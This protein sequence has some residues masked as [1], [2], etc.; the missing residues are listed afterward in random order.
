MQSAMASEAPTITLDLIIEILK[1]VVAERT[2]GSQVKVEAAGWGR[3]TSL[4]EAGFNSYDFVEIIFKIEDRFG[5]EIDYN[6][7]NGVNDARTIG[8]I[9]EALQKL[10]AKKQVS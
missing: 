4:E 3:D 5:I 10:L 7:N 9:C 2:P 6:A 1:E 8:E